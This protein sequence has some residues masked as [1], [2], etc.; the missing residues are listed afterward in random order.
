MRASE[1]ARGVTLIGAGAGSGKTHRLTNVVTAAVDPR[2]SSATPL[3]GLVAVTYTRRAAGELEARIRQTLIA[4]GAHAIARELPLAHIGTVHAVCLRWIREHAIDA[5][6]SPLIEVLPGDPETALCEALERGLSSELRDRLDTL[7][8]ELEIRWDPRVRRW[9]WLEPVQNVMTL[10]RNNRMSA[11]TLPEM[12]QR[13]SR[14]LRELM[15]EPEPDNRALD[16]EL[17]RALDEALAEIARLDTGQKNTRDARRDLERARRR[18]AAGELRWSAWIG[19]QKTNAGKAARDAVAPLIAVARRVDRHPRLQAQLHA[20]ILAVY[21]AAATGLTAY[22][23]WKRERRLVDFVDMVEVALTL[24]EVPDVRSELGQRLSLCVVDEFQDTSPAQLA[25]FIELHRICRRSTWVGDP[26]QCIFEYAGADPA[27]MEAVTNWV[28]GA[29]GATETLLDNWRSRPELVDAC[30]RLFAA[31]FAK[32]GYLPEQVAMSAKRTAYTELRDLPPFGVW[33]LEANNQ[34][35]ASEAMAEG[36]RTL[37]RAPF[38]TMVVD[39]ASGRPRPIVPGDVAVLVF[40]NAEAEQLTSAL[41][42]RGVRA[43]VARSGLLDTPEGTLVEAALGYIAD[44]RDLRALAVVEAL[45]GFCGQS[46]DQWLEG[47]I[48]RHTMFTEARSRGETC[49]LGR[50]A[51]ARALDVLRGSIAVLAPVEALDRVLVAL[52]LPDLCGRWPHPEQRSSNLEALRALAAHYEA[53]CKQRREAAS[54]SGLLRFFAEARQ[55]VLVSGEERSSDEQHTVHG[56]ES[57]TVTTYHRAKGLEWPVVVLGSLHREEQ[58]DAFSVL[59]ESSRAQFDPT[60]PLGGRWI[61]YWPWPYALHRCAPLADTVRS[62]REGQEIQR[63]E[64]SERVR[65]LYVGFTR[66]R[67]HLILAVRPGRQGPQT[68]WLHELCDAASAPLLSLPPP[69]AETSR[70]SV[71]I[72]DDH[73]AVATFPA[74]VWSLQSTAPAEPLLGAIGSARWF[75]RPAEPPSQGAPY[76]IAP[77]SAHRDW[78]EL[79][80]GDAGEIIVTGPRL[81]LGSDSPKDWSLVGDALHAFLAADVHDS[82]TERRLERARRLLAA[83]GLQALIE[84]TDLM[85]AGNRLREWVERSWPEATWHRELP[86]SAIIPTPHGNCRV[87]GVID[88]LL[89]VQGGVVLVDHKSYPGRRDTWRDKAREYAP[90]LAA[91]AEVLRLAGKN[92]WSQWISF[93]V[94]GAVVRVNSATPRTWAAVGGEPG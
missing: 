40:T 13:A 77:S 71:T 16:A 65:L 62:S 48:A 36:V 56:P 20:F 55:R 91:Y 73:G 33:W 3:E 17:A 51:A 7:A 74:R 89:E 30:S 46:P 64:A 84:P 79:S 31:A 86:V 75:T 37:L 42:R 5:G 76:K 72:R 15:G 24:L 59:P 70:A 66:A 35:Q 11:D 68:A 52:D 54:V 92:V 23:S 29:G 9:D 45:T 78:P 27:L 80:H 4:A 18:L 43:A 94:T 85:Q 69:S 81:P 2:R 47:L 61:R 60:H 8:A 34:E 53:R 39:R 21:D 22:K 32:H 14:R 87:D 90:Q 19:L 28:S 93:A 50:S 67:D 25:L 88:L 38:A 26:K 57:V 10:A 83:S 12:A 6:L 49:E 41:A 58:R 44:R 1:D 63:R 82:S